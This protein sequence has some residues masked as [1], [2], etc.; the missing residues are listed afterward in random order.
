MASSRPTAGRIPPGW[1][2]AR[3]ADELDRMANVCRLLN[4]AKATEYE[5]EARVIRMGLDKKG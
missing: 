4:P 2:A 3:W 1:D 5:Q